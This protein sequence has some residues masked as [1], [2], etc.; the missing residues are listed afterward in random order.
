MQAEILTIGDELLRGEIVDTNT[1]FLAE[2]LLRLDVETRFHTTVLDDRTDIADAFRRAV[3]RADVV[4][5]SGGLGPTRDDLTIEV[6]AETFGRKLLLHEP[7]LA[8]LR[9]FFARFGREMAA[10]NEKQ[11]WFPEGAEVLDNPIGTAP[12]CMLEIAPRAAL[13]FCM[14]G[15]PRELYRMMDEQVL[16]RIAARRRVTRYARGALLRTFGIGESNLDERLRDL[17]LPPGVELGFRTQFPDNHV[18]PVAR[19]ATPEEADAKLAAA[20]AAIRERLGSLVYGEGEDTLEVVLGRLLAE[21]RLTLATAESCTGGL[22]A[23][24]MTAVPG[25]SAYL[26]GG[27]VAYANEAKTALLGV[28]E[29]LLAEHGAVSDAVARAMAEG[30]RGRF[31]TDFA[32]AVTGIAGPSGGTPEKPVG[33]VHV[34]LA[35]A[36]GTESRELLFAFDRE[37]NRRLAAQVA[38]DWVRRRLL[39]EPLDLPRLGTTPRQTA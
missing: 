14:P 2:R 16:P 21:R 7:S 23:E 9:A 12:G 19:A 13:V 20:L 1:T 33:L 5:V 10:I 37:R 36:S 38:M 30:A 26:R 39:G 29:A 6:L 8:G 11:A 35:D 25:S 15:V 18:R 24:R 27:V 31:G 32:V 17:A 3:S 22:I 34:A 28:P 4:L